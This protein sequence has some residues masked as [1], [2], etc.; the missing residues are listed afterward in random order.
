MRRGASRPR[1]HLPALAPSHPRLTRDATI[2]DIKHDAARH[3]IDCDI[4]ERCR[5]DRAGPRIADDSN[6]QNVNSRL[7]PV[8]SVSQSVSQSQIT[9]MIMLI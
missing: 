3:A 6:S 7:F 4:E 1:P 2:E 9:M 5:R 8:K